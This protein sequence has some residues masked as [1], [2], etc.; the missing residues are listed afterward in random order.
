[1]YSS[2]QYVLIHIL[3][4]LD[5][6]KCSLFS[7]TPLTDVFLG[8]KPLID[9]SRIFSC[10]VKDVISDDI[11]ITAKLVVRKSDDVILYAQGGQDFANLIIRFL[12]FSLGGVLRKLEGNDS[13]GGID[14]LCK[15][16]ADLNEDK[17]F[18]SKEAKKRLLELN[19][20]HYYCTFLRDTPNQRKTK[21]TLHKSKEL[22]DYGENIRK[23]I[24]ANETSTIP[25]MGRRFRVKV[26]EMYMVTDDLVVEPMLSPILSVYLLN[27]FKTSLDD[28]EEKVIVIGLK[29]VIIIIKS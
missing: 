3:Q 22:L 25:P 9:R 4:V 16:I 24:L 13:L 19:V 1:M 11:P 12:T 20:M 17:Y 27:R 14:G 23:M 5:L 29:E 10:D 26:P 18:M 28:L 6:L 8:M 21:V 15:S 2:V 7:K